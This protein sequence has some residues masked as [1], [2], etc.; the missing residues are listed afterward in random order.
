MKQLSHRAIIFALIIVVLSLAFS[1]GKEQPFL[2][3]SESSCEKIAL[4]TK[5]DLY[6]PGIQLT[7]PYSL[8]IMQ[9]ASDSICNRL[10][11]PNLTLVPSH[12]YLRFLP[13]DSTEYKSL[14]QAGYELFDYP[15]DYY[16]YNDGYSYHE[17]DLQDD[18]MTWQ[19]TCIDIGESIPNV[20]YEVL[21]SCLIPVDR[22]SRGEVTLEALSDIKKQNKDQFNDCFE[23]LLEELACEIANARDNMT[24][25]K[26]DQIKTRSASNPQGYVTLQKNSIS[27]EPLKGVTVKVWY[28]VKIAEA[29]TDAN[30]H[31]YIS[32]KYSQ[33]P[34]YAVRFKNQKG[35]TI[36][37]SL[38]DMTP[39]N[40]RISGY[41]SNSGYNILFTTSNEE[42]LSAVVNNCAY[43]Y[44]TMCQSD[45][46]QAP[47][48]NLKIATLQGSGLQ[49]SGA[50]MLYHMGYQNIYQYTMTE[51]MHLMLDSVTSTITS[52]F[53]G[54]MKYFLPDIV[55]QSYSTY[56]KIASS[57]YHELSHASHYA[58]SGQNIWSYLIAETIRNSI[59]EN[60]GYGD[61][62]NNDLRQK[63]GELAE[64]W[65][66]ANQ[67]LYGYK[68]GT[69]DNFNIDSLWFKPTILAIK[70]MVTDSLLTE[71]Q[72]LSK[73]TPTTYSVD[74]L[75]N[76]L[77]TSFSTK[78]ARI[79]DCF[80]SRG[81]LTAQT[82]W[83]II[84]AT[85]QSM[86]LVTEKNGITSTQIASSGDTL[87]FTSLPYETALFNDVYPYYYPSTIGILVNSSPVYV[88]Y[89]G[90]IYKPM[91]RP[92]FDAAQW[93][94]N[95][96]YNNVGNTTIKH[97]YYT[98][99]PTDI[100]P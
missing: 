19:Y 38:I 72:I 90:T 84:N 13:A 76:K 36:F 62:T 12:V 46:R 58:M 10:N 24:T 9:E 95:T 68:M 65:A 25:V 31:Y 80:A 73:M 47:P 87:F 6:N 27:T 97:Y 75:Y 91:T 77:A 16:F 55:I 33:N 29:Y 23:L 96:L 11:I 94:S 2:K 79:T 88:Q 20:Y 60:N 100:V 39:A 82:N 93:T 35:F 37:D 85:G 30:G 14:I 34:H 81:A 69:G 18:Q 78:K 44:Y 21:D 17:D 71:V 45:G 98:I 49:G 1:C 8:E 59:P 51:I 70:Q 41:H 7:N 28:F 3:H 15:L 92:F 61:G 50:P 42:W 52:A 48:S 40:Y 43:D 54:I 64:A 86:S 74:D 83:H 99:A 26:L 53:A 56:D 63:V 5:S 32:K 57:V 89:H 67:S 66:F 4:L 22:P